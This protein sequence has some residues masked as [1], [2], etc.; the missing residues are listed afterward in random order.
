MLGFNPFYV[1]QLMSP[2]LILGKADGGRLY[3]G[4]GKALMVDQEAADINRP[5]LY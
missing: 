4:V 5:L 3:T 2:P 1:L